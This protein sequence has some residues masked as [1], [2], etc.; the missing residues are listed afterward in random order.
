MDLQELR[1][2]RG[3]YLRT[4]EAIHVLYSVAPRSVINDDGNSTL[5]LANFT[6]WFDVPLVVHVI[7]HAPHLLPVVV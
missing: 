7:L 1:T 3:E 2:S 4:G 5:G 6:T